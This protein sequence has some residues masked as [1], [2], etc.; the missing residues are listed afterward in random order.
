MVNHHHAALAFVVPDADRNRLRICLDLGAQDCDANVGQAIAL[1][2]PLYRG[3]QVGALGAQC[4]GDAGELVD[5]LLAHLELLAHGLGLVAK[6]QTQGRKTGRQRPRDER[7][8]SRGED[9]PQSDRVPVRYRR[10]PASGVR[11]IPQTAL[12]AARCRPPAP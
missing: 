10:S 5:A 4:I 12:P 8:V 6:Q 2:E 7:R 9:G 1:L 3:M 11:A